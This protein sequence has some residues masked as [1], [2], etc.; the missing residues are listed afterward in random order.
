MAVFEFE[1]K[2]GNT[3]RASYQTLTTSSS[4]GFYEK[5]MGENGTLEISES[6]GYYKFGR[7]IKVLHDFPKKVDGLNS[8][9]EA[10]YLS[11]I[12]KP[13]PTTTDGVVD[14]RATPPLRP[15]KIEA[16]LDLPAHTPHLVNFFDAIRD[17][18]VKLNCPAEIGFH[19]AVMVHKVNEAVEAR[20]TLDFKPGE[21]DV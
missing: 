7:D 8:W 18:N 14:S 3:V 13:K 21:F 17:K 15:Y 12:P 9:I 10:G 6:P 1:T 20:K 16:S 4:G 11:T 19:T 2:E 5:F